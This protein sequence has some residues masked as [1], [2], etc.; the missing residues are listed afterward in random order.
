MKQ[1]KKGGDLIWFSQ[2]NRPGCL[3]YVLIFIWSPQV[4]L[5]GGLLTLSTLTPCWMFVGS[6]NWKGRGTPSLMADSYCFR[7]QE[8]LLGIQ[9]Y[10][11]DHGRLA[12]EKSP[13]SNVSERGV[14]YTRPMVS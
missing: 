11:H 3:L 7:S 5:C 4:I 9:K 10:F 13:K 6:S 2:Y 14:I 8:G 12:G 1:K